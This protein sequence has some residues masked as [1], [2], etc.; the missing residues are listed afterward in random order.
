MRTTAPSAAWAPGH[1]LAPLPQPRP[2]LPVKLQN[3]WEKASAPSCASLS[4]NTAHWVKSREL[5]ESLPQWTLRP[6]LGQQ[7]GPLAGDPRTDK[8]LPRP[9]NVRRPQPLPSPQG[10]GQCVV[11]MVTSQPVSPSSASCCDKEALRGRMGPCGLHWLKNSRESQVQELGGACLLPSGGRNNGAVA[12]ATRGGLSLG[13]QAE[14]GRRCPKKG[15]LGR[16]W[17]CLFSELPVPQG[18]AAG[19]SFQR[20]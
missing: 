6:I 20:R 7:Q 11:G 14:S 12:L 3:G 10:C 16:G 2:R 9:L 4:K 8:P 13:L 17:V 19:A 5:A 18:R 15:R 1:S